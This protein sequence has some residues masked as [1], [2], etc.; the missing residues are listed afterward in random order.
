MA[1]SSWLESWGSVPG[2]LGPMQVS[3][4]SEEDLPV[5]RLWDEEDNEVGH[6]TLLPEAARKLAHQLLHAAAMAEWEAPSRLRSGAVLV[7]SRGMVVGAEEGPPMEGEAAGAR[8]PREFIA[9]HGPW[10]TPGEGVLTREGVEALGAA[11]ER[12]HRGQ[13][14]RAC[15]AEN[16]GLYCHLLRGHDGAHEVCTAEG[17]RRWPPDEGAGRAGQDADE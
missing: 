2:V 13:W 12:A 14:E 9:R 4:G 5:L 15:R 8:T 17:L 1:C 3:A 7:E 10:V 16:R 6:V 11:V